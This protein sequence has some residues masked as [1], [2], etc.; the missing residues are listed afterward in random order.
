[1]A[2]SKVKPTKQKE[3]LQARKQAWD[4]IPLSEKTGKSGRYSFTKPGS[5][6]K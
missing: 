4:V 2:N 3:R 6:K 5:N 1:M